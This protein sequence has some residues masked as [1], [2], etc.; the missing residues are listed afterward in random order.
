MSDLSPALSQLLPRIS[1]AL[2]NHHVTYL[3]KDPSLRSTQDAVTQLKLPTS[4]ITLKEDLE[5]SRHA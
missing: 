5:Q 2:V 4:L 1:P 3:V